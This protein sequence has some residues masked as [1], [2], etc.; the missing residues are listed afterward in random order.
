[1]PRLC[2]LGR[3]SFASQG[4]VLGNCFRVLPFFPKLTVAVLCSGCRG[5]VEAFHALVSITA[6]FHLDLSGCGLPVE[7]ELDAIPFPVHRLEGW[8]FEC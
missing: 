1:M 3:S 7:L 6:L 8:G 2:S 4:W 5:G